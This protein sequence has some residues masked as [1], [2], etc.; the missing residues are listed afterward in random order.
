MLGPAQGE[1]AFIQQL[2]AVD[3]IREIGLPGAKI[4]TSGRYLQS[5][6]IGLKGGNNLY[7]YAPNPSGWVDPLG[8]TGMDASGRPLSSPNYSVWDTVEL[9]SSQFP[10]DRPAHFKYA[11]EQLY[12]KISADPALKGMLP[13]ELVDHVTPGSRGGFSDRSPPGMSWHHNEQ[14]P[15]ILELIPR[16]QHTAP[17]AVQK[18]LHHSQGSGFKKLQSGCIPC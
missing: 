9:P 4:A 14:I 18:S 3:C 7:Q 8:L 6:P 15:K 17:G 1:T 5:D 10:N 11:N 16:P 13:P 2:K 12:N